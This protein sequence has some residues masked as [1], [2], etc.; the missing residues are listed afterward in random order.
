MK[1]ELIDY[2]KELT[3][4]DFSGVVLIARNDSIIFKKHME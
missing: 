3:E 2:D 4:K 1:S